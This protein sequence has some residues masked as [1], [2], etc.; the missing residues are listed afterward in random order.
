MIEAPVSGTDRYLVIPHASYNSKLVQA[1]A[2]YET[3]GGTSMVQ[4]AINDVLVISWAN[5]IQAIDK[6]VKI[7]DSV[8]IGILGFTVTKLAFT[9]KFTR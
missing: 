8:K 7:G 9:L 1:Y 4:I 5:G 6:D 2:Q 3:V